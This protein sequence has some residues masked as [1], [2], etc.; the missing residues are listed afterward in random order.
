MALMSIQQGKKY[1]TTDA[2]YDFSMIPTLSASM[3]ASQ[4]S[5]RPEITI[6]SHFLGAFGSTG[7]LTSP[8]ASPFSTGVSAG[9]GASTSTSESFNSSLQHHVRNFNNDYFF[10]IPC[11]SSRSGN[12]IWTLKSLV[13]CWILE[14][15]GPI[16]E[17]WNFWVITHSMVTWAS[18]KHSIC[19]SKKNGL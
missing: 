8:V 7:S 16:M 19:P 10:L 5:L 17:R 11:G 1:I 12:L 18:W 15:L 2:A 13:I 3:A 6:T 9:G 14:P 4:R